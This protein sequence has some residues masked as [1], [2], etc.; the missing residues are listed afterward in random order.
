M[1]IVQHVDDF[2]VIMTISDVII[3]SCPLMVLIAWLVVGHYKLIIFDSE[4]QISLFASNG[5]GR[6][7]IIPLL[8]IFTMPSPWYDTATWSR[9]ASFTVQYQSCHSILY[10]VVP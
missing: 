6:V 5:T 2:V 7:I 1:A 4:T 8:V 3:N 9:C 10:Y